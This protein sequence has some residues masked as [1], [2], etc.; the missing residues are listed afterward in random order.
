MKKNYWDDSTGWI[1]VYA[2]V[3]AASENVKRQVYEFLKKYFGD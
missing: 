2:I 3:Q 1:N